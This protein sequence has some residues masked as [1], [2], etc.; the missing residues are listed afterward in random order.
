MF[1][2][3]IF[4]IEILGTIAFPISGVLVAREKKMDI[5]GT[6]VLGAAIVGA[7]VFYALCITLEIDEVIAST[8][9]IVIVVL[10]RYL[11]IRFEW[12]LPSL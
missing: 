2:N 8:A 5:F 6:I 10:I 11:A 3:L 1:D 7:V 9:C 12:D 4:I